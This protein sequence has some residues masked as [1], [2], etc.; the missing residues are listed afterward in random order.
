MPKRERKSRRQARKSRFCAKINRY[1][2]VSALCLSVALLL[3]VAVFA[4]CWD[5]DY[6]RSYRSLQDGD[7]QRYTGVCTAYRREWNEE[8]SSHNPG[9]RIF[10]LFLDN[11]GTLAVYE[12]YLG[13]YQAA[14]AK[15]DGILNQPYEFVYAPL[16]P[17][18][19]TGVSRHVNDAHLLVSVRDK[20]GEAIA[21]KTITEGYRHRLARLD[22]IAVIFV[23]GAVLTSGIPFLYK[24]RRRH[25]KAKEKQRKKE[26]A[27]E[28]EKELL[29]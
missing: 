23:S 9:R 17:F 6:I 28:K 29:L 3:A 13:G 22:L 4:L 26:K 1:V 12:D 20:D 15:L 27:Q 14:K 7:F 18:F 24:C 5:Y 21:R 19:W 16:Q 10:V 2:P 11:G 25:Q 8:M